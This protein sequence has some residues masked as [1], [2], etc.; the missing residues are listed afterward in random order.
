M[1]E[2]METME[3][4]VCD[5]AECPRNPEIEVMRIK[6]SRSDLYKTLLSF[7]IGVLLTLSGVYA[8]KLSVAV[9]RG[10]VNDMI[11]THP[12]VVTLKDKM[13]AIGAAQIEETGQLR[14]VQSSLSN[15][16]MKLGV[17]T[18]P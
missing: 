9:T 13:D 14:E 1:H 8:T 15:I 3:H 10:D 4:R 5:L 2:D 18:K 6:I 11:V 12:V 16:E 17:P 7:A